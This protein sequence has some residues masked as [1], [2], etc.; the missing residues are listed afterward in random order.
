MCDGHSGDCGPKSRLGKGAML[1]TSTPNPPLCL[2]VEM[3]TWPRWP[4]CPLP[5]SLTLSPLGK[6]HVLLCGSETEVKPVRGNAGP[7]F[8]VQMLRYLSVQGGGLGRRRSR[9]P[10][11]SRGPLGNSLSSPPEVDKSAQRPKLRAPQGSQRTSPVRLRIHLPAV[12]DTLG[13]ASRGLG[14]P[15]LW[16]GS[17]SGSQELPSSQ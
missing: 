12:W 13:C 9:P 10:Q 17:A 14:L 2:K 16:L 3:D 1:A 11:Q 15:A 8:R 7:C 5:F 6:K 4:F